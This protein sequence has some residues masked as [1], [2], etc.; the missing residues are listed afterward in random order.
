MMKRSNKRKFDV[1][2]RQLF[3]EQ[4]IKLSLHQLYDQGFQI[5]K[6]QIKIDPM[7]RDYLIKT[8]SDKSRAIFNHNEKSK[9]ND[10]KRRQKNVSVKSKYMTKFMDTLNNHVSMIL[11]H[12]KQNDWVCIGSVP[13]CKPQAAH[14]DYP[15]PEGIVNNEHVPVNVL[16]ALSDNTYLNVW[17]GS[18]KIVAQEYMRNSDDTDICSDD[19]IFMKTIMMEEGDILLFRGDLVHGGAGYCKENYRLHCFMDY[20]YRVPNRTWLVHGNGSE[21]LKKIIVIDYS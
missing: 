15:P 7:V 14:T 11:P 20:E 2:D 10:R 21:Y 18:H 9:T 19:K 1:S 13:G 16:V 8:T 4:L 12:L 17:P 3:D 6:K 5:F